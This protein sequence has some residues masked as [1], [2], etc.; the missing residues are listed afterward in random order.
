MPAREEDG[1]AVDNGF[2]AAAIAVKSEEGREVGSRGRDK[3]I[4]GIVTQIEGI[5]ADVTCGL[6]A[7]RVVRVG[8]PARDRHRMDVVRVRV[9]QVHALFAGEVACVVVAVGLGLSVQG[10][11]REAVEGIIPVDAGLAGGTVRD[12]RDVS[13]RIIDVRQ[14]LQCSS[15]ERFQPSALADVVH[16]FIPAVIAEG[17]H[18]AVAIRGA[19]GPAVNPRGVI[20]FRVPREDLR[21]AEIIHSPALWQNNKGFFV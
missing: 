4:F 12:L 15:G 7:V 16:F 10:P 6:V 19:G 2:Y 11:T 3:A 1:L 18:K 20:P 14:V 17:L 13:N 5:A 9:I 8:V 21:Q